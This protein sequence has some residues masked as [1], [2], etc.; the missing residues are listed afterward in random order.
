M[1]QPGPA[2]GHRVALRSGRSIAAWTI[3]GRR[4]DSRGTLL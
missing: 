4:K 1:E 2:K 3:N